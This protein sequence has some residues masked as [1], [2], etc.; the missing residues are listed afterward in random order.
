MAA[1]ELEPKRAGE[2]GV[3][4]VHE[5]VLDDEST[6]PNR[7]VMFIVGFDEERLPLP[8]P[9]LELPSRVDLTFGD[10]GW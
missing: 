3:D 8:L 5:D 2:D 6:L 4:D 1:L 7:G 9:T 10:E